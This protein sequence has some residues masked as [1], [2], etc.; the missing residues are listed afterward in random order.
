MHVLQKFHAFCMAR[1][2]WMYVPILS[3]ASHTHGP[4]GGSDAPIGASTA[5]L[6]RPQS[7]AELLP[8]LPQTPPTPLPFFPHN[9]GS[10]SDAIAG[11]FLVR[12][13]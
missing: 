5:P 11:P 6:G 10:I 9:L 7:W 12:E 2:A 1:M 8:C 4:T 13:S 3:S